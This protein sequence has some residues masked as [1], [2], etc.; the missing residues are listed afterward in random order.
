MEQASSETKA[1][2]LALIDSLYNYT[3][4]CQY[5][6]PNSHSGIWLA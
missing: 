3:K 6:K 2:G 4:N 1:S 5:K